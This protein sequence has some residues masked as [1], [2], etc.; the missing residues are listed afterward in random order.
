M[1]KREQCKAIAELPYIKCTW[2]SGTSEYRVTYDGLDRQKEE[3][4]A[5]YTDDFDD[6]FG[7]ASVMSEMRSRL[8]EE[9]RMGAPV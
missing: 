7:T 4:A 2:L 3:D 1:S 8:I 6:A 9:S 5:Y